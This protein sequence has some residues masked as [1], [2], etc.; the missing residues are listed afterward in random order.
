ML[1][2]STQFI[3]CRVWQNLSNKA[4]FIT[5]VYGENH[6]GPRQDLW[7]DL[8]SIANGMDDARC[9]LG[10]FND[11]LYKE[12]RLGGDEIHDYEIKHFAEWITQNGLQEMR[13]KGP[14]FT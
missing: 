4:F 14:H 2:S 11:V 7:R 10:D 5:Y 6:N 13:C 9:M 12:D 8:L 3:H 1:S